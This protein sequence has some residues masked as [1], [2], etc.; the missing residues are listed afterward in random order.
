LDS[1]GFEPNHG[2]APANVLYVGHFAG[3]RVLLL[4]DSVIVEG[5]DAPGQPSRS[6]PMRLAGALASVKVEGERERPGRTNY[7]RGSDPRR[8]ITGIRH[9]RQVRYREVYPGIDLVFYGNDE[10]QLAYDLVVKPGGDWKAIR[11]AFDKNAR[12]QTDASESLIVETANLQ[13]RHRRPRI[14]LQKEGAHPTDIPGGF[15]ILGAGVVGFWVSS[16]DNNHTLLIDPVVDYSV[17]LGG[18]GSDWRRRGPVEQGSAIA[19]DSAGSAYVVGLATSSDCPTTSGSWQP[20]KPLPG[21]YDAFVLKLSPTGS[22]VVYATYLGGSA[23]DWATGVAVDE[24]GSAYVTGV[25]RSTDFPV[26]NAFQSRLGGA[27]DAFVAKLNAAGSGLVFSTYLGGSREDAGNAIAVDRYGA[28]Y[29]AGPSDS[30]D[31]PSTAGSYQRALKAP[32]CEPP[33]CAGD[34]F[35]GKIEALPARLSYLTY[36]GGGARDEARALALDAGGR[37]YVTGLTDSLDFP[38]TS[39]GLQPSVPSCLDGSNCRNAFVAKLNETGSALNYSTYVGGGSVDEA[40]GIAVDVEG[41]AYVAGTTTSP[42]FPVTPG[43]FQSVLKSLDS[44]LIKLNPSGSALVWGT[45]VG[46]SVATAVAVDPMGNPT[47]VGRTS[48]PAFPQV[49]PV[50]LGVSVFPCR[51]RPE[52]ILCPDAFV[53]GFDAEGRI[54][55]SSFLGGAEMWD[56]AYAVAVD[57]SGAAYVT[58]RADGLFPAQ[59][60]ARSPGSSVFITKIVPAGTSPLFNASTMTNAASFRARWLAPGAIITIFRSRLTTRAGIVAADRMPLPGVLDG[61]SVEINGAAVPLLAIANLDGQEQINLQV[62]YEVGR[63]YAS[64]A[65][66]RD[67]VRSIPVWA[68]VLNFDPGLFAVAG[69]HGAIQHAADFALVTRENPARPGEVVVAYATGLGAVEPPVAAGQP[70]PHS[71]LSRTLTTPAVLVGGR[72]AEVLFCGLAPG[73]VGLYQ[74]NFVVPAG[75]GPGDVDVV[76]EFTGPISSN[77]VKMAIR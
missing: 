38:T 31:L 6:I 45:Y 22:E 73:H 63:G 25:T 47:I 55:H 15:K 12:I 52:D 75:I 61:I 74:I 65:V 71:P 11:F 24:Q 5:F 72:Q 77:V 30:P 37:V 41:N 17:A 18:S 29:V 10:N 54:R 53:A 19:V 66:I 34:G 36:L 57:V 46:R 2:Q 67:G 59:R 42:D 23:D 76:V 56:S 9:F 62:P 16:Y 7:L 21:A 14:M 51:S 43:A 69:G 40:A 27:S 58:G 60:L 8:W 1:S 33:P 3:F 13:I 26:T 35:V 44:F 32:A 39:A 50:Q 4:A 68:P 28:A 49:N 70:A 64:V 48:D 20:V